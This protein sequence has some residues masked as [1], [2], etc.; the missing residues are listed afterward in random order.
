MFLIPTVIMEISNVIVELAIPN[1]IP[2][3]KVK[4]E[5]ETHPVTVEAEISR[6]RSV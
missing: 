3:K 2:T 6:W 1:G 4:G 5:I